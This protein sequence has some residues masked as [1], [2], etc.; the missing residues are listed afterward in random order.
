MVVD[1]DDD[2]DGEDGKKEK[3]NIF[4]IINLL[5]FNVRGGN[6]LMRRRKKMC[7]RR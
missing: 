5:H 6:H 3:E 4:I 7:M 2:Y 1:D